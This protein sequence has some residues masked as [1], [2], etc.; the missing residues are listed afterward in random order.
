M[1]KIFQDQGLHYKL[2]RQ[3]L[4]HSASRVTFIGYSNK[5]YQVWFNDMVTVYLK[6]I[7]C[8]PRERINNFTVI[9]FKSKS[10]IATPLQDQL[11]S[12]LSSV[13]YDYLFPPRKS[14]NVQE[15]ALVIQEAVSLS[16]SQ[17]WNIVL[18]YTEV[19]YMPHIRALVF[20]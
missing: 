6:F 2:F 13:S 5:Q 11:V 3:I 18:N 10:I 8:F 14:K 1:H 9:V 17:Y 15:V 16:Y 20:Y 19:Q 12:L 7:L 4:I